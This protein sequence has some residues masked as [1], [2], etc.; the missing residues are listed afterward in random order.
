MDAVFAR[1]IDA[2]FD[3]VMVMDKDE[4]IRANRLKLLKSIDKYLL[5]TADYSK[6]VLN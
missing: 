3:A 4:R 2:F 5:H 1:A 6:I